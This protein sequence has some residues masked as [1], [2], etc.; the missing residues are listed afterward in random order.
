MKNY[1]DE[2]NHF[3][4]SEKEDESQVDISQIV[5]ILTEPKI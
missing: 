1:R 4:W 3:I 2:S 5:G